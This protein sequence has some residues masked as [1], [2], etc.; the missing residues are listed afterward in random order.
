MAQGLAGLVSEVRAVE[1]ARQVRDAMRGA[2]KRAHQSRSASKVAKFS[3][4]SASHLELWHLVVWRSS[5]FALQRASC[6]GFREGWVRCRDVQFACGMRLLEARCA[7][8]KVWWL[9]QTFIDMSD[10]VGVSKNC[11]VPDG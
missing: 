3:V 4:E 5:P 9:W 7:G 6:A 10:L 2:S 11:V 8:Q 1:P